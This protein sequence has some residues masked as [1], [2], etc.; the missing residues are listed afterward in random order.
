MVSNQRHLLF[1]LHTFRYYLITTT[2]TTIHLICSFTPIGW[3][4]C[5]NYQWIQGNLG[6]LRTI[7]SG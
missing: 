2:I 7:L 1:A 5:V 4:D 3:L 6:K